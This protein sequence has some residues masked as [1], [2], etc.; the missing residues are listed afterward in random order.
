MGGCTGRSLPRFFHPHEGQRN[1]LKGFSRSQPRRALLTATCAGLCHPSA[2]SQDGGRAA[3]SCPLR[4]CFVPIPTRRIVIRSRHRR[5]GQ[6][7]RRST[8]RGISRRPQYQ[9]PRV[10]LGSRGSGTIMISPRTFSN[11]FPSAENTIFE[12]W[13]QVQ[14]GDELQRPTGR[15]MRMRGIPNRRVGRGV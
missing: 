10:R 8:L 11:P 1:V 5:R 13:D 4:G 7:I 14:R 2:R 15:C 3:R 9:F 6:T 12:R